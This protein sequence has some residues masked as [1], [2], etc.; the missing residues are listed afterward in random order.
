M[1]YSEAF[2]ASWGHLFCRMLGKRMQRKESCNCHMAWFSCDRNA[3]LASLYAGQ[4]CIAHCG[5]DFNLYFLSS[6][7]ATLVWWVQLKLQ[8]RVSRSTKAEVLSRA[9]WSGVQDARGRSV[10]PVFLAE[11]EIALHLLGQVITENPNRLHFTEAMIHLLKEPPLIWV[12]QTALVL[13]KGALCCTGWSSS[14][15]NFITKSQLQQRKQRIPG[16]T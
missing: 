1:C 15:C 12:P 13:S 14:D 4:V 2:I 8:R 7:P 11:Q 9:R 6:S 16:K 5:Y 3:F 10:L